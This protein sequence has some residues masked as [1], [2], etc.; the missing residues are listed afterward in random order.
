MLDGDQADQWT[1]DSVTED[2]RRGCTAL[3]PMVQSARWSRGRAHPQ[4]NSIFVTHL[5]AA[6]AQ[7]FQARYPEARDDLRAFDAN[8]AYTANRVRAIGTGL[9]ERQIV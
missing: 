3:V 2:A 8:A 9:R 4:P 6:V 5:M 1:N 7:D